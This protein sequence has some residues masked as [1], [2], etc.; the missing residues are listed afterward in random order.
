MDTFFQLFF[1]NRNMKP[2][3]PGRWP[4]KARTARRPLFRLWVTTIGLW[5]LQTTS[6]AAQQVLFDRLSFENGSLNKSVLAIAQDERGYIWFGTR[7][8]L[9]RYDGVRLRTA[10][11]KKTDTT[12]PVFTYITT[13]CE[14]PKHGLWIGGADVF[15]HYKPQKNYFENVLIDGTCPTAVN[16][17]LEDS[18]HKLQTYMNP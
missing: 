12:V 7:S 18:G 16:A 2:L 13:I 6:A 14:A 17:T 9:V 1:A 15:M 3:H 10:L 4:A 11:L 5:I 8:G